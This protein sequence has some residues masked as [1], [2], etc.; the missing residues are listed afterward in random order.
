MRYLLPALILAALLGTLALALIP[1]APA[2]PSPIIKPVQDTSYLWVEPIGVIDP[3][4]PV[5]DPR[6]CNPNYIA[7]DLEPFPCPNIEQHVCGNPEFPED[8]QR[9]ISII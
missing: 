9:C 3:A 6:F 1:D 8:V 4:P 5:P 7:P 2:K